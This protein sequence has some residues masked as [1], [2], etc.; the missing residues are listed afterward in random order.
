M[1]ESSVATAVNAVRQSEGQVAET[2]PEILKSVPGTPPAKDPQLDAY[3]RKERE[4]RAKERSWQQK[5]S[6]AEAKLAK[7][8]S[9]YIP[10]SRLTDPMTALDTLSE[11]G[12][13]YEKLTEILLNNPN[14]QDPAIKA[15]RA[16]MRAI[17]DAQ[18]AKDAEA[19]NAVRTQYEAAIKSIT[20]E[21]SVMVADS[22]E[23]EMIASNGMQSAVV[24]LIEQTYNTTG[25]LMDMA[26]AAKEVETYLVD[27]AYRMAQLPKVQSRLKPQPPV[28]VEPKVAAPS[29]QKPA[30]TT[31]LKTL[32]NNMETQPAKRTSEHER[33]A[34]AIAAFKG[35][36]G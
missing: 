11:L 26:E 24:E 18:A 13:P 36:Q 30:V 23:Y 29:A 28:E 1:P 7:Y 31:Q 6:E 25:R 17:K 2:T 5:V 9:D 8:E 15:L 3:A 4:L 16:E 19:Q 33:I 20:E 35:T 27:E 32:T 21:V 34:R 22:P 10:K 14:S 12:L